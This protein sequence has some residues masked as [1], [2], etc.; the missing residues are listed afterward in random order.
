MSNVIFETSDP[1]S[2]EW[3]AAWGRFIEKLLEPFGSDI[4]AKVLK[5]VHHR[6]WRAGVHSV[7][8]QG[9]PP[10]CPKHYT[11][12]ERRS[13]EHGAVAGRLAARE[14]LERSGKEPKALQ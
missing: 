3:R 4:E 9:P 12:R 7:R 10:G 11:E 1:Q 14:Y 2:L 6:G 5:E 13:W 8:H